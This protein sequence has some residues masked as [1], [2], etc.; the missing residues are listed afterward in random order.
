MRHTRIQ[1]SSIR[2]FLNPALLENSHKTPILP[3]PQNL[4]LKLNYSRSRRSFKLLLENQR[5]GAFS[6]L[7]A[8]QQVIRQPFILHPSLW[9]SMWKLCKANTQLW[10][11]SPSV[12]YF[13]ARKRTGQDSSN[14][15]I[16]LMLRG[17]SDHKVPL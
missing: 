17:M 11:Y 1:N 9:Y 3:S 8:I 2:E 5:L 14:K 16:N 12:S 6:G 7:Y 15:N 13:T 4:I 10:R